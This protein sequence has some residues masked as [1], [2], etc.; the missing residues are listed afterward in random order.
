MI[1]Y[2]M[3]ET[4]HIVVSDD[5]HERIG[6]ALESDPGIENRSQF[7]RTAMREKLSAM[8]L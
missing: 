4:Y 6:K 8:G 5:L 7:A 2:T 1:S 3:S